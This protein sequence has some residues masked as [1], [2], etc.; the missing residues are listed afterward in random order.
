[1]FLDT[2]IQINQYIGS[3][4]EPA[5]AVVTL[6]FYVGLPLLCVFLYWLDNKLAERR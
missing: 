1:M 6:L 2:A 3:L 4:Q 5:R